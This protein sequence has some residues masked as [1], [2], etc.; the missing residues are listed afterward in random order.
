M[1]KLKI[2]F[3]ILVIS[4][5]T[6][7]VMTFISHFSVNSIKDGYNVNDSF[8]AIFGKTEIANEFI[9]GF[10][11]LN[12]LIAFLVFFIGFFIKNINIDNENN[13]H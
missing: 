6:Y 9:I 13:K 8:R 10:G 11:I 4:S 1:K 12:I 7:S 2:F 3:V 5:I